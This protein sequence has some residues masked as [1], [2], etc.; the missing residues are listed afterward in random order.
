MT[1][2]EQHAGTKDAKLS[3]PPSR[4]WFFNAKEEDS[5]LL[6]RAYRFYT[7]L[8]PPH[9]LP[10]GHPFVDQVEQIYGFYKDINLA[11][12]DYEGDWKMIKEFKALLEANNIVFLEELLGHFFYHHYETKTTFDLTPMQFGNFYNG[13]TILSIRIYRSV[14]KPTED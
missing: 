9:K 10:E 1:Y 8:D 4:F 3:T 13:K 14:Q 6:A 12:W 11:Y 7:K 2:E 5:P